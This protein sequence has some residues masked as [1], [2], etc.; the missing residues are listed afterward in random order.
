MAATEERTTAWCK[1]RET[2]KRPLCPCG[3]GKIV[4]KTPGSVWAPPGHDEKMHG[5]I[6]DYIKGGDV[7]RLAKANWW[8]MPLCFR[9][10]EFAALIE[11]Q[12]AVSSRAE[13]VEFVLKKEDEEC[14]YD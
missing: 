6:N 9:G 13:A 5:Y 2:G 10:G 14:P 12:R 7:D 8:G 3:C 1:R 4:G 11:Q